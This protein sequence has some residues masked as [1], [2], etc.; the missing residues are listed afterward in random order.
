MAEEVNGIKPPKMVPAIRMTIV[1]TLGENGQ[2]NVTVDGPITDK[3]LSYEML[4]DAMNVIRQ[5]HMQ[6]EAANR[7]EMADKTL[8]DKLPAPAK[9]R[10]VT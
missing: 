6:Q 10:V 2:A 5:W 7:I 3:V 8:L 1:R 4:G 9:Q